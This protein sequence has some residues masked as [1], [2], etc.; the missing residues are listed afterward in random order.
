M[1]SR[2][3]K[4]Y[5]YKYI[6][7]GTVCS[8]PQEEALGKPNKKQM[9]ASSPRLMRSELLCSYRLLFAFLLQVRDCRICEFPRFPL[10]T[11]SITLLYSTMSR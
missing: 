3:Q 4:D 11:R 8:H 5:F 9:F 1:S 10:A 6:K 7:R 2:H